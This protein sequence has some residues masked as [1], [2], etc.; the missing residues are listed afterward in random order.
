MSFQQPLFLL[1]LLAVPLAA[2][3][4]VWWRRRRPPEGV[5]HPD[6]DV[7]AMAD[8][9]PRRRRVAPLALAL[10]ALAGFVVALA[11]PEMTRSVPRERATIM[12]AIDV[13]GS[14]AAADVQPYRLRAAQDAALRFAD[15]VPRQYQVG[16]I[17]FSG[18]ANLLVPPTTDRAALRR[19]IEG[20]VPNG[21]TAIGEAI[22]ASL[23]AIRT[24][25]GV[26]QDTAR[27]DAARIVLLS[28]GATTVGIS[29][30][31]AAAQARAA[32]VPVFTVALGTPD[33]ILPNGQPVPPDPQGLSDIAAAT[34]GD[35]FAT[36]DAAAV[37]RVYENLGSFL[38]TRQVTSEATG[39]AAGIGAALLVLAG[40]AAWRLG[41]RL[42]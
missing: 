21:A 13:S 12:L 41:P 8:T 24:A 28:D 10:L 26:T 2:W 6:L 4:V 19:A 39:W 22:V 15:H 36:Q 29:P 20:L 7:I 37:G 3:A 30:E 35:S 18:Q 9:A 1:G 32:G 27:L 16:L 38:G 5:P 31:A 34:G 11:R 17:S 40:I 23:D 14:M 33:G 42:S 25:Q